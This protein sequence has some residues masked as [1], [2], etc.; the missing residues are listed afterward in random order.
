[1][2]PESSLHKEVLSLFQ[3]HVWAHTVEPVYNDRDLRN[4][5]LEAGVQAVLMSLS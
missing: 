4:W 2:P 5:P 3:M 1:M